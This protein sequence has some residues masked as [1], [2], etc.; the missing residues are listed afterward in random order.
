MSGTINKLIDKLPFELHLP[1]Y[2]Y[3][4]PGTKL[5]KR[6]ARGDSG[7]NDL[8]RACKEHDIAY[9]STDFKKRREA[10]KR[11][12]ESAWQRVKARNSSA[13]EKLAAWF[14]TNIMKAKTKIGRGIQKKKKLGFRKHVVDP[15][16]KSLVKKSPRLDSGEDIRH[17]LRVARMAVKKAGGKRNIRIPRII[18]VP[19]TGGF[20]ISLFAGLSA[21]G[22]LLG[23][24]A[25]VVN[26]INKVN[27][28]RKQLAEAFRHNKAM[29]KIAVGKGLYLGQFRKKGLGLYVVKN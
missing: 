2:Q 11:L 23:A 13:S 19:K 15:V 27:N 26:A 12:I 18:P 10:D 14:V 16:R 17:A 21:L 8:D 29:E 1:K 25:G 7:I 24:G 3:C 28:A 22:T 6:L 20:L 9:L 5:E 4:G